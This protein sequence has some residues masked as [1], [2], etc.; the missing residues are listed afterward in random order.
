MNYFALLPQLP[1]V[2]GVRAAG[3]TACCV[4]NFLPGAPFH[5]EHQRR[6]QS[7]HMKYVKVRVFITSCQKLLFN[8]I[9]EGLR[10]SV[11]KYK[12]ESVPTF[13]RKVC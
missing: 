2:S 3:K 6:T 10:K 1:S 5:P 7:K 4:G 12:S 11:K 9:I 8:L 13:G